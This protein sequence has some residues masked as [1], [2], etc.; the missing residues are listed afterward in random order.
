MPEKIKFRLVLLLLLL[1]LRS[2]ACELHRS[3]PRTQDDRFSTVKMNFR[4]QNKLAFES[5]NEPT[6]F[7][8]PNADFLED[9]FLRMDLTDYI[10]RI[11]DEPHNDQLFALETSHLLGEN[12]P[13]ELIWQPDN[14][15]HLYYP[16]SNFLHGIHS[17]ESIK[18]RKLLE[19]KRFVKR[20]LVILHV[21]HIVQE[22]RARKRS[23]WN[24]VVKQLILWLNGNQN[25]PN[26]VWKG[27]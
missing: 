13:R 18:K 5:M 9:D 22:F 21:T 24:Q 12:Y 11:K 15:T 7:P 27:L 16:P 17:R 20:F 10:R 6:Y 25:R 14:L 19:I 1:Q 2:T 3:F 23:V 26:H 8:P 4:G